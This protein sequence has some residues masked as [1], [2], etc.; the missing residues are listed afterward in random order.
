VLESFL[1]RGPR[2]FFF[3][4][5]VVNLRQMKMDG[6]VVEPRNGSFKNL[7]S[8]CTF[9]ITVEGIT[10]GIE[11]RRFGRGQAIGAISQLQGLLS[12]VGLFEVEIGQVV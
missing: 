1:E 7:A 3:P 6:G 10:E 8:L 12:L 5:I 11:H 9:P 4:E 2:K